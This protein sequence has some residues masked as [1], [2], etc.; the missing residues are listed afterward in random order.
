[1]DLHQYYQKRFSMLSN[2]QWE[3]LECHLICVNQKLECHFICAT[4]NIST[5]G[6]TDVP[7]FKIYLTSRLTENRQLKIYNHIPLLHYG[8]I[9]DLP[10]ICQSKH[11][12]PFPAEL[13]ELPFQQPFSYEIPVKLSPYV[14]WFSILLL[15]V[16]LPNK[17]KRSKQWE[18]M[19]EEQ[20]MFY[21]CWQM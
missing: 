17:D 15:Q 12:I 7:E 3:W 5:V 1:M 4:K 8:K 10:L 13:T 14:H 21:M 20:N 6:E 2:N 9:N 19:S 16:H 18:T 11:L